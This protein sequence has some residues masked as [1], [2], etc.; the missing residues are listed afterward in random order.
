M[1]TAFVLGAG[2]G[3]RLR[4]LTEHLP[5]PL[6]HF[7][8]RPL[9][10]FAFD[11]LIAAGV[12]RLIV[13]THHCPDAYDTAFPE[14]RYRDVPI[15]FVH[16]P[17][18]LETGGGIA[19]IRHLVQGGDGLIVY[20]GDILTDLPL[21]PGLE[22]HR[23][24]D[25]LATLLLRRDHPEQRI[26]L[27][28]QSGRILDIRGE[29]GTGRPKNFGFTGIYY[30]SQKFI[31]DLPPVSKYSVVSVFLDLIR[32]GHEILGVPAD[33]GTWA[34]LGD[35]DAYLDTS[36]KHY[37]QPLVDPAASVAPSAQI[38]GASVVGAGATVAAD[39]VI[40]DSILWPGSSVAAGSTLKRCVVRSA[41]TAS[42][43]ATNRD[44]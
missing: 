28:E 32:S 21:E 19:N 26:S 37:P 15:D 43:N 23:R 41:V 8:G 12:T 36:A 2:L 13:N 10:T 22:Q 30:L 31:E 17:V 25:S 39:A 4:P 24:T 16:E 3:T 34:D 40:Q 44:F 29:L 42:G 9:I 6:V 5:K 1:Q 20:N 27:D 14:G 38:L 11:H 33:Q 18:L 7:G 35:R